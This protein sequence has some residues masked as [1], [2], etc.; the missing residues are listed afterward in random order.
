MNDR[1]HDKSKRRSLLADAR[2][3]VRPHAERA[4]SVAFQYA[5][6]VP[7]VRRRLEAEYASM[8]EEIRKA[9]KPYRERGPSH[10]RLP[11]QGR[12]RTEILSRVR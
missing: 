12:Q 5:K 10:V 3:R 9:A 6:R 11:E 4:L 7:L 1:E 2:E 8:L